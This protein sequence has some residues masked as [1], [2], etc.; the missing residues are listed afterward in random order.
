MASLFAM[1]TWNL[2]CPPVQ[3]LSQK[4]LASR[5]GRNS[6]RGI[7]SRTQPEGRFAIVTDV[8][9]GMRWTQACAKTR[10]FD[11]GRRSRSVL[12]PR[13]WHQVGEDAFASC[14]R[15][16][17]QSPVSGETTKETV[18]TIAQGMP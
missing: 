3:T 1:T 8:G 18:K 17:Q 2:I 6:N 16:R 5:R 11:C 12:V 7:A 10:R 9:C 13:R 4:N 14:R 15:R